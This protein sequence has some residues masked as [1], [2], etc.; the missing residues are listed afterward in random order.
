MTIIPLF[1][2]RSIVGVLSKPGEYERKTISGCK[3]RSN[4]VFNPSG[5]ETSTI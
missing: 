1:F 5:V 2:K 3:E 4:S